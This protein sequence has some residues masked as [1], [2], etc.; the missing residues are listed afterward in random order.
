MITSFL[1]FNWTFALQ[2]DM[3]FRHS[4]A[5]L[6]HFPERTEKYKDRIL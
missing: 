3:K 1:S 5:P 2:L 4:V 6:A